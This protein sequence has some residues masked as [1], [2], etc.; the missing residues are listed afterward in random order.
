[1]NIGSIK[2][3]IIAIAIFVLILIVILVVVNIW[4]ESKSTDNNLDS[5]FEKDVSHVKL[6]VDFEEV[7]NRNNFYA[8]KNIIGKYGYAI[9]EEGKES[10]YNML[11][12]EYVE[13]T[14]ISSDTVLDYVDILGKEGL[15]EDQINNLEIDI[16]IEEMLYVILSQNIKQF[17]IQLIILPYLRQLIS[18]RAEVRRRRS[19]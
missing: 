19:L 11:A 1:M 14:N 4:G 2:K 8:I 6:T 16:D 10:L 13:E 7:T 15:T 5:D 3:W 17:V 9:L 18:A 12:P